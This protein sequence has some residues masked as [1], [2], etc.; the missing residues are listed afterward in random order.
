MKLQH[1]LVPVDLQ[2]DSSYAA[3]YGLS[4]AHLFDTKLTLLHVAAW[5]AVGVVA[6]E[7][8]YMPQGLVTRLE[9]ERMQIIG[10]KLAALRDEL[11]AQRNDRDFVEVA[12]KRGF[13]AEGIAEYAAEN[14]VDLIVMESRSTLGGGFYLGGTADKVS[15][16]AS[17]PV[18]ISPPDA[19][20]E[21]P[22]LKKALVTIDYSAF[23][24]PAARFACEMVGAG[25]EVEL[26]HV[27]Q[28]PFIP[29][30]D[31]NLSN[32]VEATF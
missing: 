5:Q 27:W 4:I 3:R 2:S 19:T 26:I 10:D 20:D 6:V 25:G 15:R 7:P 21:R 31:A 13:T 14:A 11:A 9:A 30:I 1:I 18:L 16:M 24:V 23:S 17:C 28:A 29:A 32:V 12:I 22:T 8:M